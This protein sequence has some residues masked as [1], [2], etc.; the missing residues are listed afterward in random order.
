MT[1][2]A[3][4]GA[5]LALLVL[6]ACYESHTRGADGS[7][8]GREETPPPSRGVLDCRRGTVEVELSDPLPADATVE[9]WLR[10]PRAPSDDP[11]VLLEGLRDDTPQLRLLTRPFPSGQVMFG[12]AMRVDGSLPDGGISENVERPLNR[13]IHLALELPTFTRVWGFRADGGWS[14]AGASE[15]LDSPPERLVLCGPTVDAQLD[16]VRITRGFPYPEQA[17]AEPNVNLSATEDTWLFLD[18]DRGREDR[19]ATGSHRVVYRGDATIVAGH[20]SR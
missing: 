16:Q 17:L 10:L 14:N 4:A 3:T 9:M 19:D 5:F 15:P 8:G 2:R 13:W 18:F 11:H 6:S 1:R 20:P 7:D 12:F